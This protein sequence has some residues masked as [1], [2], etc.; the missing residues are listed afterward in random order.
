MKKP[1]NKIGFDQLNIKCG[2]FDTTKFNEMMEQ[3]SMLRETV[4]TG[5]TDYQLFDSLTNDLFSSFFKYNPQ[6]KPVNQVNHDNVFNR[7]FL[8]KMMATTEYKSLRSFT[9]LDEVNSATAAASAG[10]HIL[11]HFKNELSR[12]NELLKG[13]NKIEKFMNDHLDEIENIEELLITEKLTEQQKQKLMKSYQQHQGKIEEYKG[14][15][16]GMIEGIDEEFKNMNSI[17]VMKKALQ[18][19]RETVEFENDLCQSFGIGK[20]S[21]Q[22][23]NRVDMKQRMRLSTLVLKSRQFRKLIELAGRLNK[24]ALSKKKVRAKKAFTEFSDI[25]MN[26]DISRVIL[27]EFV[28][29]TD[30]QLE[31]IFLKKFIERELLQ[32]K[33]GGKAPK[34]RGPIVIAIDSSSS[35]EGKTDMWSKAI[36][37]ACIQIAQREKRDARII[38]FNASIKFYT[39]FYHASRKDDFMDRMVKFIETAPSGGTEFEPPLI[40]AKTFIKNEKELKDA[41]IILITDGYANLSSRFIDEF[42]DSKKELEYSL[43]SIVLDASF[44]FQDHVLKPISDRFFPITELNNDISEIIFEKLSD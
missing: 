12:V 24:L 25:E 18:D 4:T 21:E 20:S 32:Y 28:N 14:K 6:F 34:S 19:A 41:D 9:K 3:N 37:I 10:E 15:I 36:A 7:Q 31:I 42:L 38:L 17:I 16:S 39:D 40:S 44:D 8:E 1:V 13:K 33:I 26:N 22:S 30:K 35:M 11:K 27:S 29:L 43:F 23:S 2:K 5:K